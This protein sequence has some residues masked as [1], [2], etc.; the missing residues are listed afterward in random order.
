MVPAPI[1]CPDCDRTNLIKPGKKF[2]NK[3][4][5][6]KNDVVPELM[7][8]ALQTDQAAGSQ[9][10][11]QKR[12]FLFVDAVRPANPSIESALLLIQQLT[13]K[14]LRSK[15]FTVLEVPKGLAL[16]D[17]ISWINQQATQG[18]VALAIQTDAF[19]NPT[20]R[21]VSAFYRAGAQQQPAQQLLQSLVKTVPELPD[22]GAKPDTETALGFLAFTRQV[23]A[24]AIV[25]TL[26]FQT[27]QR[28]RSVLKRDAQAIAQGIVNGLATSSLTQFA[29]VYPP[30]NIR[31]NNQANNKQGVIANRNAYVPISVVNQLNINL[32]QRQTVRR[33]QYKNNTYIRAIDLRKLGVV[34][35]WNGSTRTVALRVVPRFDSNE[36]KQIMGQGYLVQ[37]NLKAF[38]RTVNPQATDQFPDVADLYLAEANLEG[39]NADVAFAQALLETNFFRFDGKI[40]PSQNNFGALR[41][42]GAAGETA[43]F[44][45]ARI[46]VRAHIQQLKAYASI[47]PLKQEVVSLRFRFVVRGSAPRIDLLSGQYSADPMYGEKILAILRQLYQAAGLL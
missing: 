4:Q 36:I 6:S 15:G 10:I 23:T 11:E 37:E 30:I 12:I 43:V 39:V 7:P 2:V 32:T 28:D 8:V 27:N 14:R 1:S 22:R 20:V 17:A 35:N 3:L 38:L 13:A 41:A 34:T 26:G 24:P 9:A 42:I 44:P 29:R 33:I 45:N 21:G 47:D 46:G 18:D 31:V 40:K 16:R 25:L 5:I 19:F